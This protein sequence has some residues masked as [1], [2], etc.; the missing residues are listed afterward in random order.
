MLKNKPG[1]INTAAVDRVVLEMNLFKKN[2]N[3]KWS[4]PLPTIYNLE[5]LI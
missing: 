3:M 1:Q 2:K 5:C 4:A